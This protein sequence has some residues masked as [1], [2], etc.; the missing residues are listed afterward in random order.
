MHYIDNLT[1]YNFLYYQYIRK[2]KIIFKI[3]F[4]LLEYVVNDLLINLS[5]F[6]IYLIWRNINE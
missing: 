4:D 3:K 1:I 5:Y 2:L 6:I